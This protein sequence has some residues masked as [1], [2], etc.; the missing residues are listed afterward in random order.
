MSLLHLQKMTSLQPPLDAA[1]TV[2]SSSRSIGA[3]LVDAG[4]LSPANA[5]RIHREQKEQNLFFGDAALSL[6]FVTQDDIQFALSHQF[7]YPYL[8]NND[9]RLSSELIAAY[10]PFSLAVE[11]LRAL[12][13]QLMLRWFDANSKLNALAVVSP[14]SGE[15]RSFIAANLAVVFSQLGERVLLI[16]ADLRKP[17]QHALFK[18]GHSAG[19]SSIL[20]GRA[21][22]EVIVRIT[23]LLGL[24][25]LPAGSLSPNPQ[26]LLGRS[27]FRRLLE[28]LGEEFD[29]II[30]DT[31]AAH[32]YAD[33][34]TL[35]V[36]AGAAL[37]VA[38]KNR[39]ATKEL[40]QLSR[41]LQQSGA[42]LV[43][44]VMNNV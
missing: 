4:R 6:G 26:E 33:A 30:I 2:A 32:T 12:R 3:I 18:L 37:V 40:T 22:P 23:S 13:S 44:C 36:R 8:A 31:P 38:Q 41:N 10:Q 19:L 20:A 35:A 24:S 11:Q 29:V 5:E 21:G 34:Q 27:V 9:L 15:G 39:S 25:V 14:G 1:T 7:N 28:T 17:R 43:G 42:T 16:D